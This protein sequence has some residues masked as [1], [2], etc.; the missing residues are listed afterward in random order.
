MKEGCEET[1]KFSFFV[2]IRDD[3]HRQQTN[4]SLYESELPS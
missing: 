4:M 1:Q 2:V 3:L